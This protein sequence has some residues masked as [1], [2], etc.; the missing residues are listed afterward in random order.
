MIDWRNLKYRKET[1][2]IPEGISITESILAN[3]IRLRIK[4]RIITIRI[5]KDPEEFTSVEDKMI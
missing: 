3:Y 1:E 4:D 2:E 5:T